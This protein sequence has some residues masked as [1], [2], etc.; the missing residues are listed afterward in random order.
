LFY[1]HHFVFLFIIS[2]NCFNQDFFVNL[3]SIIDALSPISH[4]LFK[5]PTSGTKHLCTASSPPTPVLCRYTID[6]RGNVVERSS[7]QEFTPAE[8]LQQSA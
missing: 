3:A 5:H 6:P 2:V 4:S 7:F 1:H 8:A